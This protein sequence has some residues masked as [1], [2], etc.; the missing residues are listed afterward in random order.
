MLV[1][2]TI[3]QETTRTVALHGCDMPCASACLQPKTRCCE[4][5][6]KKGVNCKRCP[7]TALQAAS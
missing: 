7:K 3:S 2:Y 1:F 4:K 5:Y 6:K